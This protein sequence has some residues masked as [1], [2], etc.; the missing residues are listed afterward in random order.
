MTN[1]MTK[2]PFQ[3]RWRIL[4]LDKV[5]PADANI[6][7]TPYLVFEDEGGEFQVAEVYSDDIDY[8]VGTRDGLP[9]IE[10]TWA[11]K[12]AVTSD[13]SMKFED[14]IATEKVH[15]RGWAVLEDGMLRGE[16]WVHQSADTGFA[17]RKSASP[18]VTK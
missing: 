12:Q 2:N 13:Y 1:T 5:D 15:G 6:E 17:A 18:F 11:G 9:A 7:C 14:K 16:I 8:R 3:G 10:W 4:G